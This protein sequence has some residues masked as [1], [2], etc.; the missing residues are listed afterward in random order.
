MQGEENDSRQLKVSSDRE[1]HRES[2]PKEK[3]ITENGYCKELPLPCLTKPW[4]YRHIPVEILARARELS[5]ESRSQTVGPGNYHYRLQGMKRWMQLS[6]E[7]PPEENEHLLCE[8]DDD[9]YCNGIIDANLHGRYNGVL[10]SEEYPMIHCFLNIID[11]LFIMLEKRGHW[12]S[13]LYEEC[14]GGGYFTFQII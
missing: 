4:Y 10:K 6:D 9:L 12:S 3:N 5:R 13:E 2:L 7:E 14:H 11:V 8:H 1:V